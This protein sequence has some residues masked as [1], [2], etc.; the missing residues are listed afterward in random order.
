[1]SRVHFIFRLASCWFTWSVGMTF[2]EFEDCMGSIET[3][4]IGIIVE[5][6]ESNYTTLEMWQLVE[7]FEEVQTQCWA[8]ILKFWISKPNITQDITFKFLWVSKILI[9]KVRSLSSDLKMMR[10]GHIISRKIF[11]KLK[12]WHLGWI[13]YACPDMDMRGI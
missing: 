13:S 4:D 6:Q 11:F 10:Y 9:S 7:S 2:V 1:M 5:P 3:N 12:I 8:N